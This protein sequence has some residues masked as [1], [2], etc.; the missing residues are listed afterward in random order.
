MSEKNAEILLQNIT[1][2]LSEYLYY[3]D[4]NKFQIN[5]PIDYKHNLALYYNH[6]KCSLLKITVE[7]NETK[8]KIEKKEILLK[9]EELITTIS[10]IF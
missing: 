4:F 1:N 2:F 7:I 9:I 3:Q 5:Q 10:L 8:K 6:I